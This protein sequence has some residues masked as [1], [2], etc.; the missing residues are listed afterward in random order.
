MKNRSGL[1]EIREIWQVNAV[2]DSQVDPGWEKKFFSLILKDVTE[3]T[4]NLTK[5]RFT[6]L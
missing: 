1:K 6:V 3:T 5:A 2:S 4:T